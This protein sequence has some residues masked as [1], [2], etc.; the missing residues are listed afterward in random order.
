M[1]NFFRTH[2]KYILFV[3]SFF[4][5]NLL[6]SA[7]TET[8]NSG[9]FIINMGATNPNTV[10]NG[11]KPYGLVYDLMRNF[12]VPI[13][14][15]I[16]QTKVKDGVD[17]TYN[18][19]QYKGG[20]FIIPAEFRSAAVNARITFWTGVGVGVVGTTTTSPL[21][22]SVTQ[23]LTAIPKWT[24]DSQNGDKAEAYLIA[25]GITNTA[26]PGA[27]N[28]K[29]PAT[30]DCCDDFFVMPHADP[31]WATHSRLF[32]WNL[33]CK[34]SI[35]AACHA[36]SALENMVNP[37]NRATQTNF[38][39]RKV[40]GLA[41]TSGNYALSNS[42]I[43]WGS[44]SGGSVPYIHQYP[45]EIVAQYL[46]P[47]DAAHQNGSEQ[48]DV[49]NQSA[50]GGWNPGAK[51]IAYDPTQADVTNPIRPDKT[52]A[53]AVIVYGRGFDDPARGFVMY[54]P[55]HSHAGT[56]GPNVAAQRV[57]L[58]FSFFQVQPKAPQLTVTGISGGQ[59]ILGGST[60]TGLN[61]VATSPLAGI[62]FTY[63]WS[64][65]CGGTFSSATAATTN[66]TAP[67]VGATTD[68]IITCKVTDNC[69]RV[70]FQSFPV[71]IVPLP[72]GPIANPDA[73]SVSSTC[74]VGTSVTA[75]VLTND[76][77]PGGRLPLTLTNVTGVANGV[78]T[79]TANGNITFTPDV[80]FTGP[81][82][83]TYTVCNNAV[84]VPLC[85]NGAYTITLAGASTPATA[86]DAFT[87][88][89]D[90]VGRFNVL[91]NDAVGLTVMAITALPTNGRLSINTN[92]TIT[93][94]PN[95]DF[96]GID[97]F[98]YQVVNASGGKNTATVTVT[99]TNDAC[100]GS[101][102]QAT[103]PG[104]GTVT[105]AT[106][107]IDARIVNENVD[108][109]ENGTCDRLYIETI[110]KRTR[111]LLKFNFS[112][113]PAGAT[114]TAA[115][116]RLVRTGGNNTAQNI[117]AY[118]LTN[119]WNEGLLCAQNPTLASNGAT[120]FN[121]TFTTRWGAPG[122][123]FV[124]TGGAVT[125][126][127]N[128]SGGIGGTA[129]YGWNVLILTQGWYNNT[130]P[131]EGFM[132]KD[133]LETSGDNK[134]FASLNNGTAANRPKLRVSYTPLVGAPVV[135]DLDATAD[136]YLYEKDLSK[137][138]GNATTF[139]LSAEAAAEERL[140]VKFDVKPA[141]IPTGSTVTSATMKLTRTGGDNTAQD[142]GVYQ[143]TNSWNEAADN[144]QD[145][146][147][148][149]NGATWNHRNF[150]QLW[151]VPGGDFTTTNGAV[152][153]VSTAT[154]GTGG[155]ANYNW[156]VLGIVQNWVKVSPDPNDGF[157]IKA[158]TENVNL[159][160][161]FGAKENGT[162]TLRPTLIVNYNTPAVCGPIPAR[163][164]LSMPDTATTVNGVAVNI[165][166]VPNDFFPVA[167]AVTYLII[168]PPASGSASIDAAG[169]VTYTPA[170]AFNGVRS[171][172]YEVT[173]TGSGLRDTGTVYINI[174]NAPIDA[175]NDAP[176]GDL[177]GNVQ[178][179]TV[180]TNDTDLEGAVPVS[181]VAIVTPPLNGTA[182]VN[183]SG[184]VLYTPNLNFTG[185]DTLYYSMCEPAPACGSGLCDTARVV[186]IVQNRP[187]AAVNDLRT[188]LPCITTTFSLIGNDTDPE[189][190]ALAINTLSALSIPA[191][192]TL[193]NNGDG[194]VSFLPAVGFLGVVTFT[195][196]VID[197]GV[198]PA[199]SASAT[200]TITVASPVNTAPDA[201][202]DMETINMDETSY[203]SVRDNDTD[204]E[205]DLLRI[206]TITIAPVH[207]TAIVLP[208]G[209]VQYTPNPGYFGT[210][211]LSYQLCDSS[212]IPATCA[213]APPLCDVATVTYTIV[214]PN[215]VNAIN[216]ENS[217]WINTPVSGGVMGNDYDLEG[218]AKIFTGFIDGSGNPFTSG[219]ITVS[220]VDATGAPVANAGTLTINANGTYTFTPANNFTGVVTVPY[221]ITDDNAN[222]A[223]D[224]ALLRITVNPYT[225]IT[226][227]IIANNDENIS[228]GA[229]VG[230]NVVTN[231]RD[232]QE[233]PFAVTGFNY[234]T[235]GD[236][237]P[238]GTGVVGTPVVI[239]GQTTTGL[240]VSNA[241]TLTLNA[242]GSYTFVPATDFHGS[243]DVPYT[244]CDNVVPPACQTAI[245][246]IDVLP[247][248]NGALND[249]PVAGDDFNYTN[250][251]TPVNGSFVNNDS[252][253]NSDP[254]S[255]NGTTIVPA[256]P[257]TPIGA[258]LPTAK[259][260]T[261][262][263]YA[264][265]T[266][267]YM[268][269]AGYVGPDSASYTICDVTA[270]LPNPLCTQAFI[271]LLVG[272]NNTTDAINDENSTW[273][274]VNVNG[275]VLSND[276]DAEGHTQTFGSFLTQNLGGDLS[277]GSVLGGVNK[278][279]APVANAGIITFAPDGSYTFD[280]DPAF[281][282]VVTVPY[283]LCDNGNQ[284]KCDTAYLT[285]T[286]DPLPN[287]GLNSVIA[288][289]DENLSYGAAVGGNLFVNDRDPQNDAFAV[290]SFVG[291]TVGTP[292][293]VSGIDLNGNPVANAG[294]LTINANG[295]Y[296]Y[297][298]AAGFV[299]SINVPYTITDAF[300]AISTAI[301]HIDVLSD[302]NGILNDPPVA[303]DDFGY[304]TI[305]KPVTGTFINND[306]DPNGDPVSYMGVTI[307]PAGPA[308]PIG[309]PVATT[310][311]GTV[312]FYANG[313]YLYTPPAGYVGPDRLPYI[314]CDVT[315]VTPQPLCADATIHLL[316]GP[317]INIAG[318]VWD[319][320]NGNVTIN[321]GE[322]ATNAGNTLYVN[323]VDGS[324]NVV[325][326]T[327]VA[328]DG[329]YSFTNVDPGANYSLQ[330]STNQ[331]TVGLPAPAVALPAG[332]D[333][334]GENRNGTID[335]GTPGVIDTRNFG[336]TNTVNFD[337]GIE[338]LPNTDDHTT[339]IT[340]PNLGD[341]ITLNGGA[342]PPIL[343]GSDPE[344]C[345][346]G[347]NL[348][349]KT[350]IIDAV[351]AN[352][353]LYYNGVL[354][355]N[356]QQINNFDPNLLQVKFTAATIGTISTS[357]QYS[358]VDLAGKKD[359][360]PAIYEL[361]WLNPLP[362]LLLSFTGTGNKCDAV[363]QWKTSS[364][365][366][367]DK[368]VIEQSSNGLNFTAVADIKAANSSTG[369][370]YQMAIAQPTGIMYYRLKLLDKDGKYSYSPIV[371][372]RTSCANADYLTVYPNPVSTNL[373]VSFHTLYKGQANLVIINAVGQ[374]L[375]S[376]KMQITAP[377]NTINLDIRNYVSGVYMLYL[378]DDFG[379]RIGEVQKIIKN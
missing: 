245:L 311:G 26:F 268:P 228:Y 132:L 98:T 62:T 46:G 94:I 31:T 227:S 149:L 82:V 231:D 18:G 108:I 125:S 262:Q 346:G 344:D 154:G 242:N 123:D 347:C 186:I 146:T 156:N 151:S 271:H 295:T 219:S 341:F 164:P 122:G 265:G 99:V 244:I 143:A 34:G 363:L 354:V 377:A 129:T 121:T 280:P 206:P 253:P 85:S 291:G 292:G 117:G 192:G 367:T 273:Q 329:T 361:T 20:T 249:P 141:D 297:T 30:L 335:G 172:I 312:Q 345:G 124:T 15:V 350:A 90:S 306:S 153:S 324:G 86:N 269:P 325:A 157:L 25:A 33:D 142:I 173:H 57:F 278:T 162:A 13:K 364:E 348:S 190:G 299:G 171:L 201:V 301:L 159:Q 41:G 187:P 96:A 14:W 313:T 160:K 152:T 155:T 170:T 229:P 209:L 78:M 185:N 150:T 109:E 254:V 87:M 168:T 11:L 374:Q 328:G 174:N 226:N 336:F 70:S 102:L 61:V 165:P 279:G 67:V 353:E 368:F 54:E 251:N 238:D 290:T 189:T 197:N 27:Y 261:I 184:Q 263:Y 51:I 49:P 126:V 303:G 257:A 365:I 176:A 221:T 180:K 274:N 358:Y 93:Y 48:I 8:I 222:A 308:T 248:L 35:W 148:A 373:T 323:L 359:P 133:V 296:T 179:I 89:E 138:F 139:Q 28:W 317:G 321:G 66:Y 332:W 7:Q 198:T 302:P 76:T 24:L 81:L 282:G 370:S 366:N 105:Y 39:T 304:T 267:L 158:V 207:G 343:S 103:A 74:G 130:F 247:D 220:G 56:A 104:T 64:S 63:L 339:N 134:D 258:P 375:A 260:G 131:N 315:V 95:T 314:I 140:L 188:M 318:R 166:T 305:N 194:T 5:T 362:V 22:V 225:S 144:N 169:I 101:T 235:N 349:N 181:S 191:A 356:G 17:F 212:R 360:T 331:G 77:D 118:R 80:N 71:S 208:N 309:G 243:I 145:N 52:N 217:T 1:S 338:Q 327:A 237:T 2:C 196:T 135:V 75:N 300:G 199:I 276:F 283:R 16:S 371:T 29:L 252:D 178:T 128:N 369:K 44:H 60:L 275:H 205:G 114:I 372:V 73:A 195:Y 287:T 92:N 355:T 110:D 68:C 204:P 376:R 214:V 333:H 115:Q 21:T 211:L 36:T 270:I 32:S 127:T 200:V 55:A 264:N 255:L 203:Y 9:S 334:T 202:N 193:T 285:I 256:G 277:S 326:T 379:T 59:Q 294:T 378:A 45:N 175:V 97:V 161:V 233:N 340:Q 113:I 239:G 53:A 37:A 310:Q 100:D 91:A 84:P 58:N 177:S 3:I 293:T 241:G 106:S 79:F 43:L 88:K 47:T 163:A 107:L 23:N 136:T 307:V 42:L 337:F 182:T 6:A 40:A 4:L 167:G 246:H 298:P 234:D 12:N 10:G 116:L 120:W 232:P 50:T 224:R 119:S 289:N 72:Q 288:N 322:N 352:S 320:A 69:G 357:F 330:L 319:D 272:V 111:S 83:L 286:V 259:G 19:V 316:V 215:T 38:L 218:N 210:D 250:V 183:G 342:N 351:P 281:T 284:S 236:G 266:Y 137:V 112:S 213:T 240:Q 216:D 147:L 230:G 65:T 223:S